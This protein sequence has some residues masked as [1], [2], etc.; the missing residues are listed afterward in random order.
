LGGPATIYLF[1]NG[2]L[3]PWWP[4]LKTTTSSTNFFYKFII[5]F[6]EPHVSFTWSHIFNFEFIH[7]LYEDEKKKKKAKN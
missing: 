2:Q 3:F 4:N 1:Y 5:E 6:V 7:L